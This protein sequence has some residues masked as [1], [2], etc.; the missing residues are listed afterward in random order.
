VITYLSL[1]NIIQM[2]RI[3]NLDHL[4]LHVNYIKSVVMLSQ[5]VYSVVYFATKESRRF[6]NIEEASFPVFL[7]L[8]ILVIMG[9]LSF[10]YFYQMPSQPIMMNSSSACLLIYVISGL[11]VI[12]CSY[13]L[14]PF[15]FL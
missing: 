6:F 9:W 15:T 11:Q 1:L 2:I 7:S 12:G 14:F 5:P 3:Y 13:Q 8:L 10:V 4:N